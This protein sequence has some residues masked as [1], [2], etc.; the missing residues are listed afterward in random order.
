[1]G[2]SGSP[3][4]PRCRRNRTGIGAMSASASRRRRVR[5]PVQSGPRHRRE[6]CRRASRFRPRSAA[7]VGGK[8][9][10][11]RLV[12]RLGTRV[13]GVTGRGSA[14]GQVAAVAAHGARNLLGET[15]SRMLDGD[16]MR[17]AEDPQQQHTRA[18]VVQSTGGQW[19]RR[20]RVQR[21]A[22]SGS[23]H[24]RRING[25]LMERHPTVL[26][27]ACLDGLNDGSVRINPTSPA[28]LRPR[29]STRRCRRRPLG[30]RTV[31]RTKGELRC[32]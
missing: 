19:P 21:K 28:P 14:L 9:A 27:R 16:D 10:E 31:V 29:V 3:C 23:A 11:R 13:Q 15:A 32:G 5:R 2:A 20:G 17:C 18:G 30:S 22:K 1:M 8:P 26:C 6:T 4:G 12:V 24:V 7:Q 25:E